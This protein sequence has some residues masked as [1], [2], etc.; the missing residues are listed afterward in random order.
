MTPK[1][2]QQLGVREWQAGNKPCRQQAQ[3]TSLFWGR[4]AK[5]EGSFKRPQKISKKFNARGIANN[6][7][8]V[9]SIDGICVNAF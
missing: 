5:N 1:A 4:M 2:R 8:K 3:P 9:K 6:K 7:K